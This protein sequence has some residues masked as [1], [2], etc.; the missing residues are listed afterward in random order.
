MPAFYFEHDTKGNLNPIDWQI[1]EY[2]NVTAQHEYWNFQTAKKKITEVKT[3]LCSESDFDKT[4]HKKQFQGLQGLY[5]NLFK[6]KFFAVCLK[7][8]DG[9]VLQGKVY[10]SLNQVKSISFVVSKC[11]P[12][13]KEG[14]RCKSR[15]QIDQ[16]VK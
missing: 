6:T 14:I 13:N 2:V 3:K 5:K 15:Y 7:N 16:F 12:S 8:E 9:G 4:N 1:K 11:N 10:G